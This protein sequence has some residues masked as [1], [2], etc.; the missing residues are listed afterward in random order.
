MRIGCQKSNLWRPSIKPK[1]LSDN[2]QPK[3]IN[4][5]HLMQG[6]G[7]KTQGKCSMM[8]WQLPNAYC[9]CDFCCT[10]RDSKREVLLFNNSCLPVVSLCTHSQ[11]WMFTF[12][13]RK[14]LCSTLA[15]CLI[16]NKQAYNT[17]ESLFTHNQKCS[18]Y[19]NRYYSCSTKL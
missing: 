9:G 8:K 11:G 4:N 12:C 10:H 2:E 16:S 14:L 7:M 1:G 17:H 13:L 3:S 18:A 6:N 15:S 5:R 19:R